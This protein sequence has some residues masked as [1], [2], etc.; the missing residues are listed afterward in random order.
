M[1]SQVIRE[2]PFFRPKGAL[3]LKFLEIMEGIS[4][5]GTNT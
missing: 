1:V 2:E 5:T 3:A 4:S